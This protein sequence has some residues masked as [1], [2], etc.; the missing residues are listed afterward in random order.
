[1]IERN[2]ISSELTENRVFTFHNEL[3]AICDRFKI[4]KHSFVNPFIE[5]E[6]KNLKS[7]FVTSSSRSQ[8]ATLNK[9]SIVRTLKKLV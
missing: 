9:F 8:I 1:M 4:L 2:N 5:Q 7:Q 3:V 6:I